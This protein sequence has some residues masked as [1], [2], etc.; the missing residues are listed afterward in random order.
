M[1]PE[2]LKA[3]AEAVKAQ[4]LEAFDSKLEVKSKEWSEAARAEQKAI[5]EEIKKDFA[6]QKELVEKQQEHIDKLDIK[7][8]EKHK[9]ESKHRLT[10]VIDGFNKEAD[11][12]K[13]LRSGAIRGSHMFPEVVKA[14]EFKEDMTQG[15]SFES[16]IVVPP[17]YVPGI[18]YDPD[19]MFRAR[20]LMPVGTTNSNSVRVVRE[21][22]YSDGTAI[23]A[24]NTTYGQSDFDL[25]M[26][27]ATVYKI[28]A[29]MILSEELL[30]D[31][32]GLSSYIY[33]RLPSKVALEENAQILYGTGSSEISGLVT[34]ATAYSDNIADSLVTMIDVLAQAVT[35][36]KVAEYAAS[37]ILMHPSDVTKYLTLK[38]D[39]TG[40]YLGPWV[41]T[42]TGL[43]IAGVPVIETTAITANTF[44]VGDFR[45]AAQVFDRRQNTVEITN[46]NEDNFI[47]GML[48][49][50]AAERLALAIY[51]P[52]AF[53]YGTI[54][55]ALA[56]GSA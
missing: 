55:A 5:T 37:A 39:S 30:E 50:R 3:Q 56:Q 6:A 34:N 35:Q 44:F 38:K 25:K 48:T 36:I 1:T 18:F 16:T 20:N 17:D 42:D 29:H 27:D 24:E 53:L 12:L 13:G 23:K 11:A 33:T 51:R 9:N 28:T 8:Q 7:L 45:R 43:S 52:S 47:K 19:T 49:V 10:H 15:N 41:Y 26:Y 32:D 54:T 4:T 2:E 31:V 46:V 22:A 40:R 14:M 21:E